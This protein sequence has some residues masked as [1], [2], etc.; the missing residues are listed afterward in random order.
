MSTLHIGRLD[1]VLLIN[2]RPAATFRLL[3]VVELDEQ[4][5]HPIGWPR[6]RLTDRR[7]MVESLGNIVG[8][9]NVQHDCFHG[10]CCVQGRHGEIPV[11]GI[12]GNQVVCHTN[13]CR[14]LLN[15]Y[16][17]KTSYV[18]QMFPYAHVAVDKAEVAVMSMGRYAALD[19][20]DGEED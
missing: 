19:I 6:L 15:I 7:V 16:C 3:E 2:G 11:M 14:F 12:P 9:V 5:K 10:R 1:E 13:N 17:I 4:L 20:S 8:P 18:R